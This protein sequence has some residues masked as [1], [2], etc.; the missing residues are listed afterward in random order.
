MRRRDALQPPARTACLPARPV[1]TQPSVEALRLEGVWRGGWVIFL[2]TYFYFNALENPQ[3]FLFYRH[4]LPAALSLLTIRQ[5]QSSRVVG[6]GLSSARIFQGFCT[7]M[8]CG[9]RS[10]LRPRSSE[11]CCCCGCLRV[12]QIS[13]SPAAG[14]A[15]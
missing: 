15:S 2:L 14:A 4:T 8:L 10:S 6:S 3:T 9:Q 11:G 12:E 5:R 1:N 7:S 13:V